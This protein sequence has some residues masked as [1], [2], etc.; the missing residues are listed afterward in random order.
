MDE[1]SGFL[2]YVILHNKV[3]SD[4]M[5]TA[6]VPMPCFN[7]SSECEFCRWHTIYITGSFNITSTQVSTGRTLISGQ[8]PINTISQHTISLKCMKIDCVYCTVM[9]HNNNL[10][11][12]SYSLPKMCF[13]KP[14]FVKYNF[15][16]IC[17]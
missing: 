5:V 10:H 3:S 11:V 7:F 4:I 14:Q 8:I 2:E 6:Q 13:N 17:L 16:T 1:C 9:L 15:T 12:Y